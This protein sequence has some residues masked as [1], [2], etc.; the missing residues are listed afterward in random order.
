MIWLSE[1]GLPLHFVID[2]T[3]M[4]ERPKFIKCIGFDCWHDYNSNPKKIEIH[5][6]VD[7][8]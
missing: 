5:L 7:R 2:L 4:M 8:E 6:S 3:K 1:E